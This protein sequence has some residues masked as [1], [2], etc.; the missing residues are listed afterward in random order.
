MFRKTL[1]FICLASV[2]LMAPA[3]DFSWE[4]TP[5]DGRLTGVKAADADNAGEALGR[6]EGRTYVSP[7]GKRY[8][9]G[10]TPKVASL[11]LEAQKEMKDLKTVVA[12]AP[13]D[14]I[15]EYPESSLSDWFVDV[16]MSEVEKRSGR[17]VHFG[18]VNFGGIRVDISK[19]NVLKD[20]IVSMFP[21]RNNLCYLELKGRDIRAILESM[22]E[23]QWQV[24][25]GARCV[26]S[27][28]R[29]LSV[30]IGGEALDDEKVYGVATI[31][32]LLDGGDGLSVAKNS[33]ELMVFDEFVLDVMLPY[34][35]NLTA[36]GRVLE[37][38]ADGRIKIEE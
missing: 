36:E 27:G 22:A 15:K 14:M 2:C 38:K 32:F 18:V 33:R 8:R 37:Y 31:S 20:D 13:E 25:G 29:L 11:L 7:S 3:Q 19:G 23:G 17:T 1:V 16:L 4:R 30:E 6:M 34:V 24:I 35:L 9:R 26:A 10:A 21:F 28:G 12:Y 5:A